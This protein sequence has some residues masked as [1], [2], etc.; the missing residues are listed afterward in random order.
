[1]LSLEGHEEII[2]RLNTFKACCHSDNSRVSCSML[3]E[4]GKIEKQ[5]IKAFILFLGA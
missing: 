1:L 4:K 3:A 2:R 5:R